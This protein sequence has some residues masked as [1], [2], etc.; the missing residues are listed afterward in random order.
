MVTV[1]RYHKFLRTAA[2]ALAF[3]L[4]FES[5]LLSTRTGELSKNAERFMASAVGINASVAPNEVNTLVVQLQ[6]RELMLDARERDINARASDGS[7]SNPF[8]S[9]Y[10]LSAILFILLT[11]IV[12]NYILDFVRTRRTL[13]AV[14]T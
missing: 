13:T 11:L 3:V 6:E 9:T 1:S 14:S 10:V 2:L 8:G 4:V 12:L 7:G 5:G